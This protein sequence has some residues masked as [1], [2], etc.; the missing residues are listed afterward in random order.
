MFFFFFP[1]SRFIINDDDNTNNNMFNLYSTFS[2]LKDATIK[3]TVQFQHY[4][5][6]YRTLRQPWSWCDQVTIC[7]QTYQPS[8]YSAVLEPDEIKDGKQRKI[9]ESRFTIRPSYMTSEQDT[10]AFSEGRI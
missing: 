8:S 10:T 7:T 3:C 1:V 2:K 9:K 6:S 4:P 5:K